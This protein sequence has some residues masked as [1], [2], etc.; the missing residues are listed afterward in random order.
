M[1]SKIMGLDMGDVRVGV[2]ISDES[3]YLASGHGFVEYRGYEDLAQKLI[4]IARQE[5]VAE[6]VVGLPLNMN[7][8]KGPQAAKV[9]NFSALL[10]QK[11][12]LPVNFMDERLSTVEASRLLH[13]GGK[14]ATKGLVDTASA[15]IILQAY[16]DGHQDK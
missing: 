1:M 13:A 16:L 8:T 10:K 4:S 12:G 2:A 15:T 6:I 14:K 11:S 7:G 9:E 5:Q 3:R